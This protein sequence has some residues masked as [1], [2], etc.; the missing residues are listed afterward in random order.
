MAKLD[1]RSMCS[2]CLRIST[3]KGEVLIMKTRKIILL[4]VLFS[5]TVLCLALPTL[6]SAGGY[7]SLKGVDSVKILFD[8]RDGNLKSA[9]VLL[10]LIYETFKDKALN[11]ITSK[12]KFVVVFSGKSVKLLSARREGVSPEEAKVRDEIAALVSAMSKAGIKFEACLFAVKF[13]GGDPKDL[14]KGIDHV[15]N[16]WISLFGYQANGYALIAAY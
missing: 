15:D 8:F 11:A 5:C 13:F 3:K 2:R 10:K 12:P 9:P 6:S 4:W 7:A 16:G 14:V 1:D